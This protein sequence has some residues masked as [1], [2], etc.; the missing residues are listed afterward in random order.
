MTGFCLGCMNNTN[1]GE[2]E[3][4]DNGYYGDP[5]HNIPCQRKETTTDS[6]T[7]LG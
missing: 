4:C 3:N 5:A 7:N 2:C 6:V 1:G